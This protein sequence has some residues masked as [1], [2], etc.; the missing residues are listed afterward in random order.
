VLISSKCS[1]VVSGPVKNSAAPIRRRPF[2]P[3]T[4][5]SA[6]QV[7]AIPGSSAAGSAWADRAAVADL[8]M[9]D[10][11]DSRS[12]K[13][14][15]ARQPRIVLDVAPAH[16][17]AEPNAISVN[18]DLTEPGEPTQIDQKARGRKPEGEDRHQALAAGDRL[19]AG[20][21]GEQRNGLI[22]RFRSTVFETRWLHEMTFGKAECRD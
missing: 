8:I 11:A 14:L 16:L 22:E 21:G 9:C 4:A 13:W 10:V 2:A 20:V 1:A 12:Q 15:R 3:K 19:R 6:S 7:T 18:G 17:G 5:I